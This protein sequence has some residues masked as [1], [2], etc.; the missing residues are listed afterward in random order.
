MDLQRTNQD[1][2]TTTLFK[3]VISNTVNYLPKG[4]WILRNN[5]IDSL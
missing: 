5:T 1:T 3:V 2:G 4:V